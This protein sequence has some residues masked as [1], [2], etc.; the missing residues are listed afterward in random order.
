[1]EVK[2]Q[3]EDF[4]R[5]YETT[6]WLLLLMGGGL[7]LQ[8]I[9]YLI[10]GSMSMDSGGSVYDLIIQKLA[11]PVHIKDLVFQPWSLITYPFV[12]MNFGLQFFNVL[13]S[14]LILWSFG[15]IHQQ[16]LGNIRTRRLIILA[17]PLIGLITVLSATAIVP[18]N[19]NS[20]PVETV[21]E[22]VEGESAASEA[23]EGEEYAS[24]VY[25]EEGAKFFHSYHYRVSGMMVLVVLLLASCITLVPDYPI[26]MII[27]GRVKILWVGLALIVL[28]WYN[29]G[30][31]TPMGIAVML[32]AALGYLHIYL[33]KNKIDI[34]EQ[35]WQFYA[36]GSKPKMKV[37]YGNS[38]PR[39]AKSKKKADPKKGEVSQDIIDG[40]LDKISAKG[41][42]SLSREEKELLFKASDR[43]KDEKK[44]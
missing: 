43:N 13:F 38:A 26:Q 20:S 40:I 42:E 2:Q 22:S 14:G 24:R 34:T 44:D 37:K 19:S 27:F 6:G 41:Y 28:M 21:T 11:L 25:R 39:P 10:F 12:V 16:L 35:L 1:M 4:L 32:A 8:G 36:E 23:T 7:L 18:N 17:V 9:L 15:R 5:K 33:M 3:I 31:F 29:A 30:F